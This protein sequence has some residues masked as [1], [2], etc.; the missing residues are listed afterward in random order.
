VRQTENTAEN[1]KNE[2]KRPSNDHPSS[3]RRDQQTKRNP[4]RNIASRSPERQQH[5]RGGENSE[6]TSEEL[7]PETLRNESND[8]NESQQRGLPPHYQTPT[9]HTDLDHH[10][11][12]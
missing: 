1:D 2:T 12:P 11:Q 4:T 3:H 5:E 7:P 9:P 8:S 10:V 6:N